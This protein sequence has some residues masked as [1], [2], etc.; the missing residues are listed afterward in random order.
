MKVR[1]TL[2]IALVLLLGASYAQTL[3]I[4]ASPA[5]RDAIETL[6]AQYIEE[7]GIPVEIELGGATTEQRTQYLSTVLTAQSGEID[8]YLFDVVDPLRFSAAGWVEPLNDYFESEDAMMDF[9]SVFLPG[10]IETNLIDGVLYGIPAWTDSQF[11]YYRTDLLATYG[12]EPPTTWAELMEQALIILEGEQNPNLQGFNYQG[13]PIEGTNCTFLQALWSAGGDWRDADGNITVLTDEG[14]T[15]LNWYQETLESG[16]TIPTIA[17]ETTD[18]SRQAF[19]A[20]NVIFMMNWSYAWALFQGEDSAVVGNVGVAPLPT[21]EEG[22]PSANCVGG[23]QWA[24]NPHGNNKEAAF[25]LIQFMA[26]EDSQ[27]YLATNWSQIPSR[28]S[29]YS[30]PEVLEAAPQFGDFYDVIINARPRPQTEFYGEVSDLIRST[31]N[32]FF[33][34]ALSVEEALETIQFGLEDI[35]DN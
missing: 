13:A 28:I 15:A 21:F 23:F 7:T 1:R 8:I 12:F 11:L 18:L 9:L 29:L 32:A 26:S 34:G 24:L 22:G 30:D 14:R 20:G 31:M 5:Q 19:Q 2:I 3:R 6:V 27:R 35:F 16:I 4:F 10:E 17:E 25:D 33:A